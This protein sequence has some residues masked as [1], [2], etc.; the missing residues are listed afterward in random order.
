MAATAWRGRLQLSAYLPL[1]LMA[2]LALATW[3]LLKNSPVPQAP[4]EARP[5]SREPDY[6]MTQFSMERF[7]GAGRQKLRIDGDHL[8]HYPATD[9]T[10]IDVARIRAIGA[11]GRV[12]LAHAQRAVANGDGSEV[13]LLGG[14]EITSQDA[15][16]LP[17]VMRGEFLHFFVALE[18]VSSNQKVQVTRGATD[19]TAAGLEYDHPTQK[20]ELQGPLRAVLAPRE[21]PLA[22]AQP[23]SASA[24]A[25][26]AAAPK[27]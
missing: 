14:A 22:A 4:A 2:A 25:S 9:Q 20:L 6:T 7:D 16:G 18:R 24:S 15:A 17:V 26:A 27:P 21:A 13:Q 12:T 19:V 10:E 1:A 23:A 5:V 3:W 11:D 8:R